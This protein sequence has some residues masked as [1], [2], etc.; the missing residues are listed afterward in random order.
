MSF[1]KKQGVG[2]LKSGETMT[3]HMADHIDRA[4]E[5]TSESTRRRGAPSVGREIIFLVDSKNG[6]KVDRKFIVR[7]E[8]LY[9]AFKP[10]LKDKR[11]R[12]H[13]W[14]IE[15]P[16]GSDRAPYEATPT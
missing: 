11:Y 10:Y 16:I 8:K 2:G 13:N 15:K 1:E 4:F 5:D 3:L 7:S 12:D 6:E 9:N 14:V